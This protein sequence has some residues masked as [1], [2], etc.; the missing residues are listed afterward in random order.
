MSS[1]LAEANQKQTSIALNRPWGITSSH[2][3]QSASN[4]AKESKNFI[5]RVHHFTTLTI[6]AS[7]S[8]LALTAPTPWGTDAPDTLVLVAARKAGVKTPHINSLHMAVGAGTQHEQDGDFASAHDRREINL[9]ARDVMDGQTTDL[10]I[11]GY[12]TESCQGPAV[13]TKTSVYGHA[14]VFDKGMHSWHMSRDLLP[15]E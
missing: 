6:L 13:T 9:T 14:S 7:L 5:A 2:N 15:G 4:T 8:S 10:T 11:I 3:S 12:Y 1:R